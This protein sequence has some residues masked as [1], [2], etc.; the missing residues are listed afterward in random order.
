[1]GDENLIRTLRDY[2]KPSHEGYRNTIE[3]PVGDHRRVGAS[4]IGLNVFQA[5]SITHGR[6]LHSVP[7]L[8]SISI[9]KSKFCMTSWCNPSQDEAI[10]QS[11]PVGSLTS[12]SD[13]KCRRILGIIRGLALY[14]NEVNRPKGFRLSRQGNALSQDSKEL[15]QQKSA[16][17]E[18]LHRNRLAERLTCVTVKNP[19]L[20]TS[21]V[22]SARSYP[23]MDPQCSTHVHG[24]INAVTILSWSYSKVYP[25]MKARLP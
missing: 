1:M 18:G 19:K 23:T 4:S 24:S 2:S 17:I 8:N 21:P 5:R 22:L 6:I 20:S 7:G 13:L 12:F 3:L 15:T 9:G 25:S 14:D 10:D 11:G 16:S